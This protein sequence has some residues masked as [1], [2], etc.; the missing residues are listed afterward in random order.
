MCSDE[1]CR[2]HQ[3]AQQNCGHLCSRQGLCFS[4][5]SVL[6]CLSNNSPTIPLWPRY[7]VKTHNP[8]WFL[9]IILFNMQDRRPKHTCKVLHQLTWPPQL[10]TPNHSHTAIWSKAQVC[11]SSPF[12]QWKNRSHSQIYD[13]SRTRVTFKFKGIIFHCVAF[14]AARGAC[15]FPNITK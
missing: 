15:F 10:P 9:L 14:N 13:C 7:F 5:R 6:K 2:D 1:V 4:V 8:M 11:K 12:R 3:A